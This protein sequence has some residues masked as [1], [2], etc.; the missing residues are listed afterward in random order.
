MIKF[1]FPDKDSFISSHPRLTVRNFGNDEILEIGKRETIEKSAGEKFLSRALIQFDMSDVRVEMESE[2]IKDPVFSLQLNTC[3]AFEVPAEYNVVG[4]PISQSWEMGIGRLYD[5]NTTEGVSW[6]YRDTSGGLPWDSNLLGG[7]TWFDTIP[8]Q[9]L[10]NATASITFTSI[11]AGQPF[12]VTG[13]DGT[14]YTFLA[15]GS[16]VQIPIGNASASV[17][18]TSVNEF[19]KFVMSASKECTFV[20]VNNKELQDGDC[21]YYFGWSGS[22]QLAEASASILFESGSVESGDCYQVCDAN[23]S[24]SLIASSNPCTT[25]LDTPFNKFF[26]V[27]PQS[28]HKT[29]ESMSVAINS[30]DDFCMTAS[31]SS[32]CDPY[33]TSSFDILTSSFSQSFSSSL[34]LLTTHSFT[35]TFIDEITSSFLQFQSCSFDWY[36]SQSVSQSNMIVSSQSFSSSIAGGITTE[37][38]NSISYFISQSFS[39]SFTSSYDTYLLLSSVDSGA[40]GNKMYF[41]DTDDVTVSES[42]SPCA[43]TVYNDDN[44][45]NNVTSPIIARGTEGVW[46][47]EEEWALIE[48]FTTTTIIENKQYLS[49]GIGVG[50]KD[51]FSLLVDVLTK[52]SASCGFNFDVNGYDLNFT[53]SAAGTVGNSYTFKSGSTITPF[54]G[55]LD[56]ASIQPLMDDTGSNTYYHLTGSTL[57]DSVNFLSDKVNDSLDFISSDVSSSTLNVTSTTIDEDN[58]LIGLQSG[59]FQITLGGTVNSVSIT[60]STSQSFKNQSS[61]LNMNVTD[62]AYAWINNTIPNEGIII[63]HSEEDTNVHLG[64]IKYFSQ[65]TNTIYIPRLAV[66]YDDSVYSSSLDVMDLNSQNSVAVSNLKKQ[67]RSDENAVIRLSSRPKYPAKTFNNQFDRFV[68]NEI[69]PKTSFYAIRD[70]ES[71]EFLID[72]DESYTKISSDDNGSYFNLD[73]S[74]F[75]QERFFRIFIKVVQNGIEEVFEDDNV[76]KVSI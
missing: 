50:K 36:F 42:V 33:V 6:L 7:G 43:Q 75:P 69:L 1:I 21:I 16:E 17:E 35:N 13:S 15:S 28:T 76:F 55:G 25:D 72:F 9:S 74:N 2:K 29:V 30:I 4:Y 73:I 54:S 22:N 18:I 34:S 23:T 66:K 26:Y 51:R 60:S 31:V 47:E 64:A 11:N 14:I 3:E 71:R 48:G 58:D 32:S 20:V 37:F 39:S 49:D 10:I 67:Y 57:P 68:T 19:D 53:A 61:D 52:A 65:N 44:F 62:M 59:S 70:A 56:S 5:D 24:H 12:F 8:S 45:G 38:T 40:E 41:W 63:T 27:H 46:T